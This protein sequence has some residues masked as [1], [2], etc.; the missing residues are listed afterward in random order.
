MPQV[1][2]S[3]GPL[4]RIINVR[5]GGAIVAVGIEVADEENTFG[6]IYRGM[7]G[8][9]WKTVLETDVVA[10]RSTSCAKVGN[11]RVFVMGGAYTTA[12]V[13]MY[14]N[15]AKDW[16]IVLNAAYDNLGAGGVTGIVWD[17]NANAFFAASGA[18]SGD[19]YAQRQLWRSSDGLSWSK[20]A[21]LSAATSAE[22]DA[23]DAQI[24]AMLKAHCT[25]PANQGGV[26]DG[27]KGYDSGAKTLMEPAALDN[28][29][30]G[31]PQFISA[32]ANRIKI[33][34]NSAVNFVALPCELVWGVSHAGGVWNALGI[35]EQIELNVP[36]V[37]FR[38]V[39]SGKSW[40]KV[41]EH[42]GYLP[43]GIVSGGR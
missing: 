39:D 16:S 15:N 25:K 18:T 35:L 43:G 11:K 29:T 27:Y 4:N 31:G 42:A 10:F 3:Y 28:W 40:K 24:T 22:V 36:S 41:F 32:N 37:V 21:E 34:K 33:T 14:S 38:S 23:I 12:I 5:W 1:R 2:F 19:A 13:I 30:V 8:K 7:D 26:P 9:S 20:I 6:R 17:A